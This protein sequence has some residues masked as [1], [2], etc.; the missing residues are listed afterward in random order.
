[1]PTTQPSPKTPL[2]PAG[3][4]FLTLVAVEEK[5]VDNLRAAKDPTAP[6][7]V[8]KWLWRFISDDV[9]PENPDVH[10]EYA[11]WTFANYGHSKANLTKL[12]DMIVPK[13]TAEQKASLNTDQILG[14]R[15]KAMIVHKTNE[16]NDLVPDAFMVPLKPGDVGFEPPKDVRPDER[17]G[18]IPIA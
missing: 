2:I 3:E 17:P 13:A 16:K 4:H 8:M 12:L 5:E 14:R 9:D 10:Y 11:A 7:R 18:E 15:Y 6:K 1:M